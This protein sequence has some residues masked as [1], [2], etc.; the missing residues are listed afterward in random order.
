MKEYGVLRKKLLRRYTR[1]INQDSITVKS[2]REY[3]MSGKQGWIKALRYCIAK[4]SGSDNAREVNAV[5]NNFII[6]I[7]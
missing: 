7:I 1:S 4:K 6:G 5:G 3:T 2:I